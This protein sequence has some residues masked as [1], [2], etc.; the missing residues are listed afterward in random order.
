[1]RAHTRSPDG[2]GD[3]VS[4]IAI[5]VAVF[6]V[7]RDDVGAVVVLPVGSQGLCCA[8]GTSA[9]GQLNG[10]ITAARFHAERAPKVH[11][12][13]SFE[14]FFDLQVEVLPQPRNGP[15]RG[16]VNKGIRLYMH[17]HCTLSAVCGRSG[18]IAS[19]LEKSGTMHK[20]EKQKTRTS[21]C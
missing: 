12:F 6:L 13:H 21:S 11:R 5:T 10:R 4:R 2:I 19:K 8:S 3:N 16:G 14:K 17:T 7:V 1:M 9:R 18:S 20:N 15:A